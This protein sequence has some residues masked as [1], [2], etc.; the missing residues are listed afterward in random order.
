MTILHSQKF[1]S[2]FHCQTLGTGI[3][4]GGWTVRLVKTNYSIINYDHNIYYHDKGVCIKINLLI[5]NYISLEC[6]IACGVQNM[7]SEVYFK[8]SKLQQ[9]FRSQVK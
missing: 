9:Q 4:V 3:H 8:K 2:T 5:N 1:Y 7:P 6:C